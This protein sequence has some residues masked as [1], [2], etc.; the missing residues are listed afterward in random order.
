MTA[1]GDWLRRWV[2]DGL[3]PPPPMAQTVAKQLIGHI[4]AEIEQAPDGAL[5]FERFMYLALYAPGLGYYTAGSVKFGADG[6]FVTA[7][8][9]SPLFGQCL[10]TFCRDSLSACDGDSIV[11]LGAGSG[12][13]AK[14]LL[15]TLP[16]APRIRYR[17]V[18]PSA[19]LRER[20]QQ[21]LREPIERGIDIDWLDAPPSHWRG[22]LLANEV[23]DA[24][25][26][27][28][29]SNDQEAQT[30]K[31]S[32]QDGKLVWADKLTAADWQ[33][34]IPHLAQWLKTVTSGMQ[35]GAALFLDYGGS[36]QELALR[37]NA[38]RCHYRHRVHADPLS[39]PGLQDITADVNFSAVAV[40]AK[41]IGLDISGYTTQA[42]LLLG[43]G[44][45]RLIDP[46]PAQT[47][48]QFETLQGM[49]T[50][51]LPEEMGERIKA[52]CLSRGLNIAAPGFGHRDLR[53]RL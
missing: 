22:V 4:R 30:R 47:A 44:I 15:G 23:L 45:D 13:L 34:H 38:L 19:D 12:A 1:D 32:W 27:A 42:N 9:I 10:A 43:L 35:A 51:L 11:E 29:I 41:Q 33:V 46:S 20:Q 31:V 16:E 48:S 17:I 21:T 7:P 24:L 39:L 18:E 26:V 52:I 53:A 8:E 5:P 3:P 25:P 49:K 6:D 14:Q 36:G 37:G 2:P 50:L 40:A 28:L